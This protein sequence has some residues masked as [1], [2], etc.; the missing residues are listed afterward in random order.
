MLQHDV[1]WKNIIKMSK[2]QAMSLLKNKR[3]VFFEINSV[4]N[5]KKHFFMTTAKFAKKS[6][7]NTSVER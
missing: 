5:K 2:H 7:S 6:F 1:F 3:P 4:L